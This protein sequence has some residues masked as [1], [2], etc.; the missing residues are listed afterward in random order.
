MKYRCRNL[1]ADGLDLN[2]SEKLIVRTIN[3]SIINNTIMLMVNAHD[4]CSI[5]KCIRDL[6]RKS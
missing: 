6:I 4:Y 1:C 2:I 3:T 5:S